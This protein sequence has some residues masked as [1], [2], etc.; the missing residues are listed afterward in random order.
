NHS[1]SCTCNVHSSAAPPATIPWWIRSRRSAVYGRLTKASSR[2]SGAAP[3]VAGA[4]PNSTSAASIPSSEVPDM[5]P[6]TRMGLSR[7]RQVAHHAGDHAAGL[8]QALTRLLAVHGETSHDDGGLHVAA[9]PV[10]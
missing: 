3:G 6:I 4:S 9:R 7:R 1:P 10:Q 8:V 2:H 5:S